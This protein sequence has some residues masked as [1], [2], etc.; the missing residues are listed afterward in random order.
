MTP[1]EKVIADIDAV[2]SQQKDFIK[3][4]DLKEMLKDVAGKNDLAALALKAEKTEETLRLLDEKLGEIN[5]RE[6]AQEQRTF[7]EVFTKALEVNKTQIEEL[8]K[9]G[10]GSI[11]FPLANVKAMTLAGNVAGGIGFINQLPGAVLPPAPLLNARGLIN[12][13]QSSTGIARIWRRTTKTGDFDKQVPGYSKEEIAFNYATETYSAEFLAAFVKVDRSMMQDLPFLQTSVVADMLNE[14]YIAENSDFATNFAATFASTATQQ[15]TE[16]VEQLVNYISQMKAAR[17]AVNGIV[18]NPVDYGMILLTKPTDF[19]VPGIC[20]IDPSTGAIRL[21]GVPVFEA[22]WVDEG[23]VYMGD[24]T[25]VSRMETEG[26]NVVVSFEDDK[27]IQQNLVTFRVECREVL[28]YRD[29]NALLY[30]TLS[31]S[32]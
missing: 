3:E 6:K 2:K 13:F 19:S 8:S 5:M 17:Y 4:A 28:I 12:T 25:N 1:E 10:K 24:W 32:T 22:D 21:R 15:G 26:L 20:V 11:S 7:G 14:F 29:K 30:G 27:N 23:E 9:K 31:S 16:I 18:L